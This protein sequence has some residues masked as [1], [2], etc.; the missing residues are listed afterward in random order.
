MPD[1]LWRRI[2]PPQHSPR[3]LTDSH[4]NWWQRC[5]HADCDLHVSRPGEANCHHR[6]CPDKETSDG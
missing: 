3:Y 6:E 1:H 2:D 5:E 4:G